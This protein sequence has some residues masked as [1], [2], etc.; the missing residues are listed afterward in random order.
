MKNIFPQDTQA[1]LEWSWEAIEP[2]YQELQA[3][4]LS[5]ANVE[6]WLKDWSDLIS[7]VDELFTRLYIA[8]TQHTSDEDVEK[9]FNAFIEII[10]PRVKAAD[11]S[12][13]TKLLAQSQLN[14][15]G[16]ELPLRKMRTEAALFKS[17]NL[18]LF[19]EEQKLNA[20]YNKI[21]GGITYQWEG[22]ERT[23]SEMFP[24]LLEKDRQ[25]RE[26]AWRMIAEGR[27]NHRAALNTLWGKLMDVR[28]QIGA[29]HQ[30]ADYRAYVWDQKF[31]FDYTPED[32]K[33]FHQAIETVVVPAAARALKRRQEK[34]GL[35]SIRPWDTSVDPYGDR[36]LKPFESISTLEEKTKTILDRIDPE[37]GDYFTVMIKNGLLDLESRKNKAPGAYSLG[38]AVARKPFIFMSSAGT[39]DDV[40]TLLHEC[41]HAVHEFERARIE[42][43]QH[44]AESYLPAEFAEVAS[45][46]M[47]LLATP[48]LSKD[49]G[50]FYNQT[51]TA[52][53]RITQLE[54]IISFW[55]YMALVDAFQHWIYENPKESVDGEV[56]EGQWLRLWERF[57][58]GVDYSGLDDA[59]KTIWHRQMHIFTMPFYYIEYGMAQL[60]AAQIWA[61]SLEDHPAAI[62][63]YKK[64][65]ALGSTVGLPKL[66][67]TAGAKFSFDAAT[68]K[69]SVDLIEKTIAELET[70]L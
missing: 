55:P 70:Q 21:I 4:A 16:F 13:K 20:E 49:H 39:H 69:R 19:T 6:T 52:R 29:N 58:P 26:K 64:A 35:E 45:M 34:L 62:R 63:A 14:P 66:F 38:Y 51:E 22:Q 61:N 37:F 47:E 44:R 11:Q 7:H 36:P 23:T 10:Q 53:A 5:A 42:H 8:S 31:R 2:F 54:D 59:R 65:L 68:L 17:D 9:R 43:F 18:P 25:T 41:G 12:L 40:L 46:G 50:G 30:P 60:G 56:C 1:L 48:Y 24:L 15:Q 27:L 3:G 28:L 33:T 32:C 57:M 67:E